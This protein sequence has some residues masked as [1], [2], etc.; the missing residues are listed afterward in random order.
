MGQKLKEVVRRFF[1][2]RNAG[3]ILE[4]SSLIRHN[5]EQAFPGV[6]PTRALGPAA[7]GHEATTY[8]SAFPDLNFA[9]EDLIAEANHVVAAFTVSGTQQGEFAGTA[10]MGRQ[11][12]AGAPPS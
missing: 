8:R 6:L 1:E 5:Y 4:A 10:P 9:I 2:A 11:V 3:D 7:F 12:E